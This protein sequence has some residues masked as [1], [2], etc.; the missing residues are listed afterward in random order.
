MPPCF[1]EVRD[2]NTNRRHCRRSVFRHHAPNAECLVLAHVIGRVRVLRAAGINNGIGHG[3]EYHRPALLLWS[4]R[5]GGEQ[6]QHQNNTSLTLIQCWEQQLSLSVC[7]ATHCCSSV[8]TWP[9]TKVSRQLS[10]C[11]LLPSSTYTSRMVEMPYGS[12]VG[13]CFLLH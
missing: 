6:Q 13:V 8:V 1:N 3:V 2:V 7:P 9:A 12:V 11:W 5:K 4:H 10:R